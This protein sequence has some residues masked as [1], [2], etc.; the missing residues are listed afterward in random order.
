MN[1]RVTSQWAAVHIE[2]VW[3]GVSQT[4]PPLRARLGARRCG[5]HA[6]GRSVRRSCVLSD[7]WLRDTF[8]G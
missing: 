2:S 4:E 1:M 8:Y 5:R 7:T 6:A 3:L